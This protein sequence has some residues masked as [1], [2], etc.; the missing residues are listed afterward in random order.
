MTIAQ[1]EA[2]GPTARPDPPKG[3][4]GERMIGTR[5]PRSDARIVFLNTDADD[6][7]AQRV[8]AVLDARFTN[9]EGGVRIQLALEQDDRWRVVSAQT[10]GSMPSADPS[11]WRAQVI[12]ALREAGIRLA[13]PDTEDAG[14]S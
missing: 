5:S 8:A 3:K 12:E 10:Y 1:P 9:M 6:A 2:K 11:D 4:R 7:D 13:H 14:G